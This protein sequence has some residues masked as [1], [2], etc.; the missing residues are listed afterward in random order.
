MPLLATKPCAFWYWI[1]A[2]NL[3]Q[4]AGHKYCSWIQSKTP[5]EENN[6]NITHTECLYSP[7]LFD[8]KTYSQ[9]SISRCLISPPKDWGILTYRTSSRRGRAGT[10]PSSTGHCLW[11][12]P[13]GQRSCPLWGSRGWRGVPNCLSYSWTRRPAT[14]GRPTGEKPSVW[15]P[16]LKELT[17]TPVVSL[18]RQS[19]SW[20]LSQIYIIPTEKKFCSW[21]V[22]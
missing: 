12:W 2:P 7:W 11:C 22:E 3:F 13:Q 17:I 20:I 15:Y 9:Q 21:S 8:S 6:T 1:C 10:F 4:I 19:G 14:S 16:E 5:W 18:G